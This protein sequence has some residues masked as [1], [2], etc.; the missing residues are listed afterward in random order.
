MYLY[1]IRRDVCNL[2][3]FIFCIIIS[4]VQ[5]L[6][7]VIWAVNSGGDAHTD[8]NGIRYQKDTSDSGIASDFGTSL[9]IQRIM[10][11]DQPLYQTERYDTDTF[12]YDIP[13]KGDGNYVLV[14][15]FSEVWFTASN[16]KVDSLEFI[17]G[18]I[19]QL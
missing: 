17:T 3:L 2:L 9:R 7:E 18:L 19:N 13:I 1:S 12:G 8:A 11:Q 15:K 16:Q 4:A 6:G 14:L 10:P 5:P